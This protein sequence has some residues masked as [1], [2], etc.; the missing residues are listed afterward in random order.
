MH[1]S[2]TLYLVAT[3]LGNLNDISLRALEVLK[4]VTWIAAEDTRHSAPLLKHFGIQKPLRALHDH[5]ERQS[6]TWFEEQLSQGQS[7]ALI[8]DAGTPL[9]ADPGYHIVHDLKLKGFTVTPIPGPSA[10]ITALSASG[11]PTDRFCFEGFLPSKTSARQATLMALQ[12]ETRTLIFYEAPHRLLESVKAMQAVFGQDRLACLARE[13]TKTFE[14]IHTASLNALVTFIENDSNQQRG[15]CVLLVA[16]ATAPEK[17][18]LST[19]DQKLL[20]VLHKHLPLKQASQIAA[21]ITGK[22]KNA[23]YKTALA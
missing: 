13:L 20:T 7:I 14:T 12:Q 5:N 17:S 9:I 23:F 15:E 1:A 11:L 2:G 16:G 3:P 6:I 18:E 10:V 4:Q 19:E 22:S 21:E 8:S